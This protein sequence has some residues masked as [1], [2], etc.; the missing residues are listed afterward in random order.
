MVVPRSVQQTIK[1]PPVTV[2]G[3][4]TQTRCFGHVSDVVRGIVGLIDNSDAIGEVF[5][6]G[7]DESIS[8]TALTELI[9]EIAGSSS[10]IEYIPDGQVYDGK[11]TDLEHRVPDLTKIKQLTGYEPQV[12]LRETIQSLVEHY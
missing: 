3:D 11:F 2:F 9:I 12:N 5:N 4:G 7:N 1:G 10:E 6:I 8:I